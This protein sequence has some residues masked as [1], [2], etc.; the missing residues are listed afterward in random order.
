MRTTFVAIGFALLVSNAALADDTK[1]PAIS[2]VKAQ[3]KGGKVLIEATIAD[4]TGVLSATVHHRAKGGAIEDTPMTK[5]DFED[6]FTASFAGGGETEY[7]IEAT[8]L[9][10]N[11]PATYGTA[12]HPMALGGK[13][14]GQTEVASREP[15]PKREPPAEAAPREPKRRPAK[16]RVATAAPAKPEIE[17]RAPATRPAEGQDFVVRA[18]I[19][20]AAVASLQAHPTGGTGTTSVAMQQDDGESWSAKLPAAL[21]KGTVEYFIIAANSSGE[22]AKVGA[23]GATAKTPYTISFK[24]ASGT[25]ASTVANAAPVAEAPKS[26]GP[27]DFSHYPLYR[28]DPNRP[29][30]VRAQIVPGSESGEMPDRVQILFR[31]N[32]AQ[33]LAVDMVRDENGGYGGYKAELPAQGE[34]AIFYAIVACD[35]GMSKCAVDTGSKRKWHG[36]AVATQPGS[37]MPLPLEAV[38]SKAPASL[39]E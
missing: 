5:A 7:W 22:R 11:G 19:K 23:D 4:E 16:E 24:G 31:G 12:G 33:D 6:R 14:S 9:I 37:A 29:I 28:V 17:H 39:P 2:G 10:G 36:A 38:S 30:V 15:A 18:K 21:A 34:G 8:D 27:Y 1:A 13:P 32:D 26:S 3:V 25:A 20:N 35:G